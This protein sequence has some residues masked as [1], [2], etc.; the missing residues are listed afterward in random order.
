MWGR[1]SYFIINNQTEKVELTLLRKKQ[2]TTAILFF[3]WLWGGWVKN[4]NFQCMVVLFDQPFLPRSS[5]KKTK[6]E[7]TDTYNV[8][9]KLDSAALSSPTYKNQSFVQAHDSQYI[10]LWLK[11]VNF[12][13]RIGKGWVMQV[14]E[15]LYN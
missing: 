1:L 6:S 13:T 10:T 9:A 12:Q 14:L 8:G 11:T 15:L 3:F 7:L 2:N 5:H 4:L